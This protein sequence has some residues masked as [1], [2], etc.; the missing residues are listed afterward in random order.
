M[1]EVKL[2]LPVVGPWWQDCKAPGRYWGH[3]SAVGRPPAGPHEGGRSPV[4]ALERQ[5]SSILHFSVD[6]IEKVDQ[7]VS[8]PNVVLIPIHKNGFSILQLYHRGEH[9]AV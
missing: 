4:A 2:I 6:G 9:K 7:L 3:W 5:R 8:L 1:S